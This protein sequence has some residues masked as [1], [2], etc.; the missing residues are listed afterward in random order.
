MSLAPPKPKKKPG[1]GKDQAAVRQSYDDWLNRVDRRASTGKF[2][3]KRVQAEE[4]QR[5]AAREAEAR[6]EYEAWLLKKSHHDR[7]VQVRVWGRCVCPQPCL[8]LVCGC[9]H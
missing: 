8:S 5:K 4:A 7:A 3:T 2:G 6:A 1:S 9:R